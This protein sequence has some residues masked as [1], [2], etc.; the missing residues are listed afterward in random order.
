[1]CY[2]NRQATA[3]KEGFKESAPE[4][5]ADG[6]GGLDRDRLG[7]VARG[8]AP[9]FAARR[10]PEPELLPLQLSAQQLF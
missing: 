10:A 1:M 5:L 3:G 9:V 4:I 2:K 6:L 8:A 7:G